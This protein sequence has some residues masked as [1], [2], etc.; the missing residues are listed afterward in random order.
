[1]L[2][3]VK[4]RQWFALSEHDGMFTVY[5]TE[6]AVELHPGCDTREQARLICT[7]VSYELAYEFAE[8]LARQACLPLYDHA[9]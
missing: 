9:A 3:E 6:N 1:M 4:V 5:R 7:C 8:R 2:D